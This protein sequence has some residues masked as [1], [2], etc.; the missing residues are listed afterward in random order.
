MIWAELELRHSETI[1]TKHLAPSA[2]QGLKLFHFSGEIP[3]AQGHGLI[4]AL[5]F[6]RLKKRF[7]ISPFPKPKTE[8][9][10]CFF[11]ILTQ[12]PTQI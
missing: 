3:S 4:G 11:C 10:V 7:S 2:F 5:S 9:V 8:V 6:R 1:M 12:L